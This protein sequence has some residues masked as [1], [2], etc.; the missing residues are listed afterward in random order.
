MNERTTQLLLILVAGLL[1]AH[2]FRWLPPES[3]ARAQSGGQV[4]EIVRA[5]VIEMVDENGQTRGQLKVETG[6]EAVF[7]LRDARG[8]IRVKLGASDDGAGLLLLD[9]ETNPAVH[10]LAK[11]GKTSLTLAEKGKNERAI[12]P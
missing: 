2:L 9:N 12:S 6:G 3:S 11:P 5:R 4:A 8:A 7:R 10:L 1:A